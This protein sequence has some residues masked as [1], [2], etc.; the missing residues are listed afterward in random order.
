MGFL[1]GVVLLAGFAM[2]TA[3]SAQ[4]AK[5]TRLVPGSDFH[6]VHGLRFSPKGELYAGSVAGQSLYSVDL[7]T[8]KAKVLVGPPQGMADDMAFGPGDQVVWTAIS[9]NIVYSRR[10]SG[11]IEVL[12]KDLVSVNSIT[13]S[14]DGKRLFAAQVFGGDALWELDPA[15]K[16]PRRMI[17]EG[18]GGFNSFAAGSDGWLYGPLWFKGQVVKINPDTGDMVVVADGLDTPA[19]AKFDSKDNLYAIDTHL[20]ELIRID[21]KTGAKTKVAQLSTALD[22]FAIDANDQIV[23]SNMA[24][25]GLQIVDP[26]TGAV[27]Q[28]MKGA[29]AFPADIAVATDGGRESLFVADVF[30]YRGVDGVS[31]AVR[32]IARVH[33]KGSKLEYPTGVSVGVERV[34]LASAPTGAVLVY[35]RRTGEALSVL[36]GFKSPSD[37]LELADGSI[38]VAE[39]A[40]GD[41]IKVR[42]DQ[43]TILAGGLAAPASLALGS[44][45]GVYVAEVAGGRIARVDLA[46]GAKTLVAKDLNLPKA[47]ALGPDGRLAV[48]EV[49]ARRVVSIDPRTGAV[50]VVAKDLPLGLVTKPFPLAGGIAVGPSGAIYVTSD[51]ENAI[52]KITEK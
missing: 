2:A 49:G 42:G 40:S 31:G 4:D 7:A 47:V 12:A 39:L 37:A 35:D 43:R 46:T 15:G 18:M 19:A 9:D 1:K 24:D 16:A 28:V 11:P 8:G 38:L 26:T 32:D 29:L 17:R 3:A 30:S 13:F 23:V 27:R 51:L 33:T 36:H 44:D 34:V 52:Y 50:K 5:V 14:R 20:G 6:G 10:G 22:N 21:I 48:L 25:N 45:G 41:L